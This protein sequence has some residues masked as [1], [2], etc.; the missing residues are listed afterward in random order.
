[1]KDKTVDALGAT[2]YEVSELLAAQHQHQAEPAGLLRDVD[3]VVK[4]VAV[5]LTFC[6]V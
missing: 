6:A 2:W 5:S 4:L 3:L 1:M